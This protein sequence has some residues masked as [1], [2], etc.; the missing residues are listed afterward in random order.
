MGR[1]ANDLVQMTQEDPRASEDAFHEA[2]YQ[3]FVFR[4]RAR[5]DTVGDTPR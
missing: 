1:P 2:V 5:M 3:E 4:C